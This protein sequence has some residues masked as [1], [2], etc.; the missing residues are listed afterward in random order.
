MYW[1][2]LIE[3]LA[4]AFGIVGTLLLAFNG[5]F[6]G[7]GFMAYLVSNTGWIAFAVHGQ[8]WAMLVQQLAFVVSSCIGAWVWIVKPALD[9]MDRAIG[10]VE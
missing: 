1:M 2:T 5:R 4:A 10:G 6:A 3:T 9:S 8:H 7:W